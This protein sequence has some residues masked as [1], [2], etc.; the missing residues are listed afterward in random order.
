[1]S[2][3]ET[4]EYAGFTYH[5]IHGDDGGVDMRPVHGQH[6]AAYRERHRVAARECY[7]AE[8]RGE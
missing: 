4:Y 8:R 2:E 5:V 1:M 7:L 6:Y 3:L